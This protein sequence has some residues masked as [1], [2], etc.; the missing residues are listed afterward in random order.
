MKCQTCGNDNPENAQFCGGCGASL[1]APTAKTGRH[2]RIMPWMWI[3]LP[4]VLLW[5]GFS[6]AYANA[7]CPPFLGC[8][9]RGQVGRGDSYAE[10]GQYEKA[11]Q[12]Y[13]ETLHV[14]NSTPV[15]TTVEA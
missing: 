12:E 10:L 1:S 8:E 15:S 7:W 5:L 6:I 3:G 9:D 14:L 11:I 4:V 13:D 2:R